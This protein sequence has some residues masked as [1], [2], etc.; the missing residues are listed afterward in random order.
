MFETTGQSAA[1][2]MF[3]DFRERTAAM[4]VARDPNTMS[5]SPNPPKKFAKMHPKNSPGIASGRQNGRSVSAS[6]TRNWTGPYEMG[7]RLIVRTA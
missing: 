4:S 2:Q 7:A 1:I 3:P 5:G 6:E